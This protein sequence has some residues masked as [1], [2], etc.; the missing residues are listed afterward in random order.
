MVRKLPNLKASE[1]FNNSL[2]QAMPDIHDEEW[3]ISVAFWTLA[4]EPMCGDI[5]PIGT[6]WLRKFS[7]F[8]EPIERE[9]ILYY[10]PCQTNGLLFIDVDFADGTGAFRFK[11]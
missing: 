2:S 4:R 3:Y 11:L 9:S 6:R 8:A 5:V 1:E 10:Y 7:I